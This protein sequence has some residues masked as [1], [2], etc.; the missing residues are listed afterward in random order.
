MFVHEAAPLLIHGV[1]GNHFFRIDVVIRLPPCGGHRGF[2]TQPSNDFFDDGIDPLGRGQMR[3][4]ADPIGA[5]DVIA[6]E[7]A[8]RQAAA[9]QTL[10]QQRPDMGFFGTTAGDCD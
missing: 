1:E 6:I 10:Q 2:Q 3:A 8:E 4:D 7:T 5:V 9:G